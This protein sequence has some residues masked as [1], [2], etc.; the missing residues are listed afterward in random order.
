LKESGIFT[1]KVY[2]HLAVRQKLKSAIESYLIL[3]N[4]EL[5]LKYFEILASNKV[6]ATVQQ[7]TSDF[8]S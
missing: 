8:G 3:M 5:R 4:S 2:S 1:V 6:R 7:A